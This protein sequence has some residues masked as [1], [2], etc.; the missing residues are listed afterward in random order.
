MSFTCEFYNYSGPPNKI[1]KNLGRQLSSKACS[2]YQAVSELHGFI[3]LEYNPDLEAANYVK[4]YQ[5]QGEA[6]INVRYCYIEDWIKN[7]GGQLQLRLELDPLM[8]FQSEILNTEAYVFRTSQ[9]PAAGEKPG[10]GYN[11]FMNDNKIPLVAYDLVT[12]RGPG[13][14]YDVVTFEASDYSVYTS[15]IGTEGTLIGGDS[16]A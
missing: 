7:T 2:P 11:M 14:N 10:P 6:Q 8:T 5:M 1:I 16:N 3:I 13:T 4:V 15:I 12:V 9:Q